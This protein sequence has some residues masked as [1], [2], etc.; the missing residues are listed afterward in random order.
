M[1]NM[2]LTSSVLIK[3]IVA[4]LWVSVI[5]SGYRRDGINDYLGHFYLYK[6][7]F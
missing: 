4:P 5:L 3:H 7:G 2:T 6:P 1:K